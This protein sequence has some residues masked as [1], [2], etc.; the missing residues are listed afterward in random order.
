MARRLTNKLL[1]ANVCFVIFSLASAFTGTAAWFIASQ[2]YSTEAGQFSVMNRNASIKSINLYKFCYP[3]TAIGYDYTRPSLGTVET[4]T[5][6]F[7]LKKF[8]QYNNEDI[9]VPVEIMNL[10]DPLENVIVGSPLIDLNCNIV[11]EITFQSTDFSGLSSLETKA[12]KRTEITADENNDEILLSSCVD[13]DI[14]LPGDLD[15][16]NELFYDEEADD[17]SKY[18]PSYKSGL[19][20]SSSP[21]LIPAKKYFKISYL[22]SLKANHQHFY[23][24]DED[25]ESYDENDVA[26]I[27]PE[28]T[29]NFEGSDPS[30]EA[31]VYLNSNYAPNRL[32]QYTSVVTS[33]RSLIAKYNYY[34]S[35]LIS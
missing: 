6:D 12:I 34:F 30:K 17:Y 22:S 28:S 23:Y 29:I 1:I 19:Y 7:E 11:F 25:A 26:M 5:Y 2:N 16:D 20:E 15:D 4:Y 3:E 33:L 35:F 27:S 10:Y 24:Y 9:F 21:S 14:F 18:V 8:G 32:T 31:V 13:F